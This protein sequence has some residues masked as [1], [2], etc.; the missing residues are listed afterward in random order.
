MILLTFC[1]DIGKF[2]KETL[3]SAASAW[4]DGIFKTRAKV[5]RIIIFTN[6]PLRVCANHCIELRPFDENDISS[7]SRRL[8]Q[9]LISLKFKYYLWLLKEFGESPIWIDLDTYIANNID[10]MDDLGEFCTMLGT[11]EERIM[12]LVA[13]HPRFSVPRHAM[14][15]TSIFKISENFAEE[16]ISLVGT[17]K[18]LLPLGDQ[19][20]FNIAYH[21][22][23]MKMDVLG[24][25]V[26]KEKVFSYD[27]WN[28]E[29]AEHINELN[30]LNLSW[31]SSGRLISRLYS[32][33][34]VDIV[35]F[36]FYK[37]DQLLHLELIDQNPFLAEWKRSASKGLVELR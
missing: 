19:D 27:A 22:S 12:Q 30:S 37:F 15:N 14:I 18:G 24:K 11:S 20:A 31:D 26:C 25:D 36:C 32:G 9:D 35:Q 10:Y 2:P 4:L 8:W 3:L 17:Y 21:F 34:A 33:K 16:V 29:V 1:V 23:N 6:M 7:T 28:A 5:D 13:G